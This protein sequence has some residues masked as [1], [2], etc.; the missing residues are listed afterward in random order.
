MIEISTK[1]R[2][3]DQDCLHQTHSSFAPTHH[4]QIYVDNKSWCRMLCKHTARFCML[5]E[6]QTSWS[7]V[8]G[9]W[10]WSEWVINPSPSGQSA[11]R[12]LSFE[13][14]TLIAHMQSQ[15][16]RAFLLD[17]SVHQ[18]ANNK[19]NS[20][21]SSERAWGLDYKHVEESSQCKN[22]KHVWLYDWILYNWFIN[23]AHV[24][25][26]TTISSPLSSLMHSCKGK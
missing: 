5:Q 9:F 15:Q 21:Y 12:F 17:L 16:H 26:S 20:M 4:T 8:N 7:G 14:L 25:S 22:E 10:M 23:P 1:T 6:R 2:V 13:N 24:F 19:S 18:R 11:L 3:S